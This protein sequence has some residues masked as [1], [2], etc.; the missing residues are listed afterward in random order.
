MGSATAD[1]HGRL[2]VIEHIELQIL[3]RKRKEEKRQEEK[4][5]RRG[6]R[7]NYYQ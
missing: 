4:K 3:S 1:D 5:R 2:M 6:V 7:C